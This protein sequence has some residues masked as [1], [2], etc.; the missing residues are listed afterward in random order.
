MSAA[1]EKLQRVRRAERRR[2]LLVVGALLL[3]LVAIF[4]VRVLLGSYTVAIPDFFAILNGQSIPGASGARFIVMT[5]KLPRAVLG[6]LVGLSFGA[7]GAIFQLL[8]RNP[9]ASPD[10]IGISTGASLGA[11]IGIVFFGAGGLAL[12]GFAAAAALL[13][14]ALIMVLASGGGN[15]GGRFILMGIGVAAL[16]AALINYLLTRMALPNAQS[17]AL[18]LTGSLGPAN[19]ERIRLVTV[20][21]AVLALAVTAICRRLH[22]LAVGDELAHGLGL[23]VRA[24]YWG[25]LILAVL[26]T[27][28]ATAAAGPIAFVP[29]I[30]GPL[31][32][33]LLG[34]RHSILASALVGACI[35]VAADFVAANYLPG[36]NLPVGV[37][38][39]MVGAPVLIWLLTRSRNE[40]R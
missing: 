26:L 31:A 39:G 14:A 20:A 1:V 11:V 3:A 10:I 2:P 37:L 25:G 17:A 8:F 19:W 29:L 35:V 36:G 18:W 24:T 6:T 27:A 38:T 33:G 40:G 9:L 22:L 30:S 23:P 32:R 15:T 13:V 5:D 12:S 28:V 34:G 21:L 16:G 4:A 7:A